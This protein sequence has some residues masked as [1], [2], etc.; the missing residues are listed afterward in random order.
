MDGNT[1]YLEFDVSELPQLNNVTITGIRRGQS[2]TLKSEAELKK[3]AMVTDNLIVTTKTIS[4]KNTQT[5]DFLR[6]K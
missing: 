5:K 6:L 3:G 4:R 2:K 1:V